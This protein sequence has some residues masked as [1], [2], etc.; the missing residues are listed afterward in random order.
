MHRRS[1]TILVLK[2][3]QCILQ[4]VRGKMFTSVH[5]PSLQ[6]YTLLYSCEALYL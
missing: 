6:L 5:R 1:T 2:N 3:S 4:M